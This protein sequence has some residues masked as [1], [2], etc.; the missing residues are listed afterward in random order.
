MA[1]AQKKIIKSKRTVVLIVVLLII[2]IAVLIVNGTGGFSKSLSKIIPTDNKGS[3]V[4]VME[5]TDLPIYADLGSKVLDDDRLKKL[6][7]H[8][9]FPLIPGHPGRSNPFV[10]AAPKQ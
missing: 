6:E 7:L 4:L 5:G 1:L 2:G 3:S 9:V 10:Q 8:G